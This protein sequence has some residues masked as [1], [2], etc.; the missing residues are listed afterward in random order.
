MTGSFTTAA[1]DAGRYGQKIF[2]K[3]PLVPPL[4]ASQ[5]RAATTPT[6]P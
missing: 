3:T 4:R 6:S 1:F 2:G 5:N